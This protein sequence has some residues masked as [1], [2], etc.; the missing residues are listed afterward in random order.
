[1]FIY[2]T[3][4]ILIFW[5]FHSWAYPFKSSLHFRLPTLAFHIYF[6]H[7]LLWFM[8]FSTV[9]NFFLCVCVCILLNP[10]NAACMHMDWPLMTQ[11]TCQGTFPWKQLFFTQQSLTACRFSSGVGFVLFHVIASSLINYFTCG[12]VVFPAPFIKDAFFTSAY[13]SASLSNIKRLK[14]YVLMSGSSNL[15]HWTT[16]L[17]L[18]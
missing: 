17:P 4:F 15:Y 9:I 1:M 11:E 12:H 2:N 10:T 7:A 16:C 5:K 8:T 6:F 14:L 18:C 3:L 13:V